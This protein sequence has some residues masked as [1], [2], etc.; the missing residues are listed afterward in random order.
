MKKFISEQYQ[1]YHCKQCG[2]WVSIHNKKCFTCDNV[3]RLVEKP[4]RGYGRS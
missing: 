2:G 4:N 1:E 3:T